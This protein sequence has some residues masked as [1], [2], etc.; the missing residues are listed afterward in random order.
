MF[1]REDD[2]ARLKAIIVY[3]APAAVVVAIAVLL[4][5]I[6]LV[7]AAD[8]V[9]PDCSWGCTANDVTVTGAWLG[10]ETGTPLETCEPGEPNGSAYIW[11]TINN[12]ANAGRYA[13]QLLADVYVN[14]HSI[15]IDQCALDSI[16]GKTNQDYAL[17]DFTWH[18]GE[19][20][21]LENLIVSWQTSVNSNCADPA[22]CPPPAQCSGPGNMHVAAPLIAS[23][24]STSPQCL[25]TNIDFTDATTGGES[26]YTYSWDFGDSMGTLSEQNPSYHYAAP[27]SYNV[28]LSVTDIAARHDTHTEQVQVISDADL[29]ISKTGSPDPVF[30]GQTLTYSVTVSNGGPCDAFEVVVTDTLPYVLSNPEYSTDD[31]A[32]W[33]PYSGTVALGTIV[34]GDT[35]QVL[36]KATV[37]CPAICPEVIENTATVD[38]PN[39]DPAPANN[40]ASTTTTVSDNTP[41]VIICP[42]GVTIECDESTD[43]SNTGNATATDNCDSDVEVTYSDSETPGSCP[44]EKTIT[45]TW[46][47][48]DDCG[49]TAECVQTVTVVDSI[50]PNI[51]SSPGS[52]VVE[53]IG[54]IPPIDIGNVTATDN[55]GNVTV[56]HVVDVDD[57]NTCPRIITRIYRA[58]DDCGNSADVPQTITVNDTIAPAV[59]SVPGNVTVDCIGDI[60]PAD[61]GNVTAT[62]NCG[63]VT[64]T[65]V[66]DADDGNA[67]PR[68]I[69]RTYRAVDDCGN[70]ADVTQAITVN[71]T[72][73]PV[74]TCPPGV[75]I[76]CDESTDPSNTGNATATDNCDG[77]VDF[78]YSDISDG[79]TCPELITRTWTATDDCG[80][81]A[82]CVQTITLVDST[83]PDIISA[84][85]NVTVE[86]IGDIPPIDIG[87]VTATDNCGNVTVTHV[88][89]A[90][91][92]T[93]CPRT[94]TRTYRAADDCGNSANVTQTI[95]VNDTIAPV[96]TCP[97]GVT[98]D[99]DE[100]TDPSNTGYA[101]A[102]DNCDADVDITYS[103]ESTSGPGDPTTGGSYSD[104]EY[105]GPAYCGI[106][107]RTWTATDDCGHSVHCVQLIRRIDVEATPTPVTVGGTILPTDKLGLVM[108]GLIAAVALIALAVVSLVLRSRRR[109]AQR[110]SP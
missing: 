110:G 67:C 30:V 41:P 92:G 23:F 100:S 64:V 44:Q 105:I 99:C 88:G 48:T 1:F 22:E 49:N 25:C 79:G 20:I 47:A 95:T 56:T 42:P 10:N 80:N 68:T 69:T 15:K 103:D 52:V 90:D 57:G 97:P 13:V 94:I 18:C 59:T 12:N 72:I 11:V 51:T 85:G 24:N 66:G 21:R 109:G 106:I 27:G 63:N 98:I 55:C 36:I 104:T 26:P 38:S 32:T 33:L 108:P 46:T 101:T 78:T 39:Y 17:Y 19:A 58:T 40:S 96:I 6:T 45:R 75:T 34:N 53:C 86:C 71:D 2:I 70:F 3:P 74:I 61:I 77:D 43:P 93:T 50:A 102:T 62:D 4:M 5:V 54:D 60:P 73:A 82:E 87:N 65:H 16:A 8:I 7:R 28:T 89:D 37:G 84:P 76:E 9:W 83:A 107:E 14:D 31:G 81:T 91:D 35:E 29:A